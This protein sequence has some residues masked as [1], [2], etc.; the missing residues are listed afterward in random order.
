MTFFWLLLG[1]SL[2]FAQD[3]VVKLTFDHLPKLVSEKNQAVTGT[4]LVIESART[5]TGYLGRSYLPTLGAEAGGERFQTGPYGYETQPYGH[6]ETRLNLYRGGRDR[7][8]GNIR[9]R[10]VALTQADAQR[11]YAAELREARKAYWDLVSIRET[12]NI[13]KESLSQNEKYLEMANRR[14]SRGLAAETDRL[15]FEIN[16]SQLREELESLNHAALLVQIRLAAVLGMPAETLFEAPESIEHAHDDA[17]LVSSFNPA[18]HPD[19]ETLDARSQSLELERMKEERW[20]TP[21][22]DLYGGYHLYTL[23]DR[24]FLSRGRRAD[25]AVGLRLNLGLFDGLQS[26]TDAKAFSI[27]AQGLSRQRRQR[28]AAVDAQVRIAKKDLKHG[29]EL[30]HYSEERIEQGKK[31]LARTFEEY[32]RGVKNSLDVLGAA[33]KYLAYRRQYSDRRRDYQITKSALLALLG[34]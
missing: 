22:L 8:E 34:L 16:R 2:G 24:D 23:R 6:L 14:I 1:A 31:Y 18:F 33:Q 11:V 29:H 21:S 12:A 27:H 4:S 13:I 5:R 26:Q 15:E 17:L 10:Q 20:W 28:E 9:E 7:L 25:R 32:E 3:V 30:I 19:V